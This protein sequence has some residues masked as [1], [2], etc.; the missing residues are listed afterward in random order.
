[1]QLIAGA[2]KAGLT[3]RVMHVVELLDLSYS[4]E[5]LREDG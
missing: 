5:A 1:M 3:V 2:R 4:N